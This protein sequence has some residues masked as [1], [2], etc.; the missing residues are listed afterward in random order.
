MDDIGFQLFGVILK[1]R[2]V[3]IATTPSDQTPEC[4]HTEFYYEQLDP[5]QRKKVIA[6]MKLSKDFYQAE[7]SNRKVLRIKKSERYRLWVNILK[8]M[9]RMRMMLKWMK[10][11]HH[12]NLRNHLPVQK[13]LL[14]FCSKLNSHF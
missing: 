8:R 10:N 6:T 9:S 4:F 12:H 7:N 13:H 1:H 14:G 11:S 5:N 2:L 3:K